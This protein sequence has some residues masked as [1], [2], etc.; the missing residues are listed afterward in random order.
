MTTNQ[1][2]KRLLWQ[3]HIEGWKN[4]GK[5]QQAYCDENNIRPNQLWYWN[6]RLNPTRNETD[7]TQKTTTKQKEASTA[8]IPV[9]IDQRDV[10]GPGLTM[11]L[12]NGF[13]IRGITAQT[14]PFLKPLIREVS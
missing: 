6:R 4:S 12:P 13:V 11:T 3:Q 2:E 9:Q 7:T 10:I 1:D 8:F 5:T 14:I